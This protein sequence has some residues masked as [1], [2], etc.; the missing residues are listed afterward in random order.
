MKKANNQITMPVVEFSIWIVSHLMIK[1]LLKSYIKTFKIQAKVNLL[2]GVEYNLLDTIFRLIGLSKAEVIEHNLHELVNSEIKRLSTEEHAGWYDI[3]DET[4]V[5]WSVLMYRVR[6]IIGV[7][8]VE[9]LV[10]S[11]DVAEIIQ[12]DLAANIVINKIISMNGFKIEDEARPNTHKEV[13]CILDVENWK[14]SEHYYLFILTHTLDHSEIP[15]T[16]ADF[17]NKCNEMKAFKEVEEIKVIP[18]KLAAV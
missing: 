2:P 16:T 6:Q 1:A 18:L 5:C 14:D 12:S 3:A 11:A 15:S 7:E 4:L 10:N 17:L 8:Q 9:T 13:I